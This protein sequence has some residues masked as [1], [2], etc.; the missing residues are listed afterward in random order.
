MVRN[1]WSIK[2]KMYKNEEEY[3]GF[4]GVKEGSENKIYRKSGTETVL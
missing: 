2:T 1:T 3:M 4:D